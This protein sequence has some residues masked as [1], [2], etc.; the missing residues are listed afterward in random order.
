MDAWYKSYWFMKVSTFPLKLAIA[1]RVS[2]APSLR[3]NSHTGLQIWIHNI[4]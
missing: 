2:T 3:E 1:L 4:F